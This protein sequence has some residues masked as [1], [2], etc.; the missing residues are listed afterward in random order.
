[1]AAI[2]AAIAAVLLLIWQNDRWNSE[3]RPQMTISRF[4]IPPA[5][6]RYQWEFSNSG[7]DDATDIT[8]K[9]AKTDGSHTA[10]LTKSSDTSLRLKHGMIYA[11]ITPPDNDQE[12]LVVCM[13]YS[14]GYKVFADP[15]KFYLTPY[16]GRANQEMQVFGGP[17]SVTALQ[18]SKLSAGF[19][20]AKL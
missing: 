5:L 20:C 15:P 10:L 16:Y 4:S 17:A 18:D 3:D 7:K 12:F 13:N 2:V 6:D 14:D 9:V 8:I 19:S 11:V 1:L